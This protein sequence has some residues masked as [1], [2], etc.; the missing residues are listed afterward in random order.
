MP[1]REPTEATPGLALDH[2]PPTTVSLNGMHAPTHTLDRP[3]IGPGEGLT[4]TVVVTKQPVGSWYLITVDKPLVI[5]VTVVEEL[6][7]GVQVAATGLLLLHIP[8]GV[9]SFK[10]IVASTHTAV[11]PTMGAGNGLTT[12]VAL[13]VIVRLQPVAVIVATTV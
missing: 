13:P 8:P 10:I 5:P 3:R 9:A 11:G 7:P 12:T 4:F 2:M 1:V 6:G